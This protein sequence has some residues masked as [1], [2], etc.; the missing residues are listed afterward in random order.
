MG[1][2]EQ[3]KRLERATEPPPKPFLHNGFDSYE[4]L[5][6]DVKAA[7]AAGVEWYIFRMTPDDVGKAYPPYLWLAD[8][9][10]EEEF[11]RESRRYDELY[12]VPTIDVTTDP[13][14]PY[15]PA[16]WPGQKR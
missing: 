16:P 6:A 7:M 9:I 15:R 11:R 8:D 13:R 14:K 1:L 5:V 10:S 4:E 12:P 2:N 3:L